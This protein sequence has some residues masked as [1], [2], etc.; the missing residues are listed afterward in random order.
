MFFLF[1]LE[2]FI[3]IG[4][5]PLVRY[6]ICNYYAW[7]FIFLFFVIC[8]AKVFNIDR[9]YIHIFLLGTCFGIMFKNSLSNPVS[10]IFSPIFS[11]KCLIDLHY[12][13]DC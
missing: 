5:K 10:E 12:I 2:L 8:R 9:V 1:C 13:F 6:A 3:C 4:Y 11:S 7:A